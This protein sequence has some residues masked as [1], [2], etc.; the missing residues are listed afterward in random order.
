[1][2]REND[3]GSGLNVQQENAHSYLSNVESPTGFSLC[4]EY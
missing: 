3:G 4:S 1:L 2:I